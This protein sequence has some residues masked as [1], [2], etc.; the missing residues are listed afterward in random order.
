MKL[1]KYEV[2]ISR[3]RIIKNHSQFPALFHFYPV[4]FEDFLMLLQVLIFTQLKKE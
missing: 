4:S 3:F 1:S 2:V